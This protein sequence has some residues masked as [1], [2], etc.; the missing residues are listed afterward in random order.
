MS[1]PTCFQCPMCSFE[2]PSMALNLNHLRLVH[3]ND[4]GFRVQC[5]IS[6]CS[7]TAKSFSALYSHIY[8]KHPTS[9]VIQRRHR[10]QGEQE[11]SSAVTVSTDL[12]QSYVQRDSEYCVDA[13]KWHVPLL[14]FAISQFVD[15][16]P[17]QFPSMQMSKLT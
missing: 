17:H 7:Y 4:S 14:S 13:G 15:L 9:G 11:S 6:G 12:P 2:A 8:R 16:F 1:R 10:S 3:S 5:G